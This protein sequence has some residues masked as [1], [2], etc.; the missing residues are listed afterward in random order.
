MV[1]ATACFIRIQLSKYCDCAVH[2][3]AVYSFPSSIHTL[4]I[5]SDSV[6]F[7]F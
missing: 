2:F 4:Q 1:T 6:C 5:R 3:L 7:F